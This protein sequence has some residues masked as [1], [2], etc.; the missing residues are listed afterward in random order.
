M[1]KWGASTHC[2]ERG[3]VK[4]QPQRPARF[5]VGE[6]AVVPHS[7]GADGG[8]SGGPSRAP[9]NRCEYS[10]TVNVVT[11]NV[12]DFR[13]MEQWGIAAVTPGDFLKL[14]TKIT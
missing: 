12:R 10:A 4:D 9:V 3:W 7:L 5:A 6:W 11:H 1:I 13:G 2:L 8:W 14:I